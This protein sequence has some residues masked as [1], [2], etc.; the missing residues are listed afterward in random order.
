MKNKIDWLQHII[1]QKQSAIHEWQIMSYR[2]NICDN[3]GRNPI[4]KLS[5]EINIAQELID[6]CLSVHNLKEK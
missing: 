6:M 5:N 1:D 3:M 2:T 4:D